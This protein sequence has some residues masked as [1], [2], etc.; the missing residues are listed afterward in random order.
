[1]IEIK[2]LSFGF[3]ENQRVLD[4]INVSIDSGEFVA[5]VGGNGSGKSTFVR[6]LNGL[7]L[8][9][10][11]MVKVWNMDT[12]T[13]SN[14]TAIRKKIGMV[15]QNPL[16]QFV[17][18]TVEEDVAF[19]LENLAC[20]SSL[21]RNKTDYSLAEL[22]ISHLA[23][24]SPLQLSGGQ[25][26]LAALAGVL[27]MEPECVIFDEVTS[28]LDSFSKQQV[29][30]TITRLHEKGKTI[31]MVTHNLEEVHL[32]GRVIAFEKGRIVYDGKS[33]L[34]FDSPAVSNPGISIPP[35]TE[36]ALWLRENGL[37]GIDVSNPDMGRLEEYIWQLKS[38]I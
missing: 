29:L 22:G 13:I 2:D 12:R 36:L 23:G 34:F 17:G 28:M 10:E 19:G 20:P 24:K 37:K 16:T 18:A 8:P 15:F 7:L 31:I 25:M 30:A 4:S 6:H 33:S 1:M 14:L 9:D 11:G 38:R 5:V 27:V 32:A 35:L 26:Q 21:I 3:K